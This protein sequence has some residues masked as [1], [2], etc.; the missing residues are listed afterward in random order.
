MS[1]TIQNLFLFVLLTYSI[2]PKTEGC[3]MKRWQIFVTNDMSS[4]IVVHVESRDDDLG[5]HLIPPTANYKFSFCDNFFGQSIFHGDFWRGSNFQGLFLLDDGIRQ[6]CSLPKA[7]DEYCYWSVRSDGFYVSPYQDRGGDHD[8]EISDGCGVIH[9]HTLL[10]LRHH[11]RSTTTPVRCN[12]RTK[13]SFSSTRPAKSKIDRW[14]LIAKMRR[15]QWRCQ[16]W[17]SMFGGGRNRCQFS[18]DHALPPISTTY[19]RAKIKLK[20]PL[21]SPHL[22]DQNPPIN[23]TFRRKSFG[24]PAAVTGFNM[25]RLVNHIQHYSLLICLIL[26]SSF[27]SI[28]NACFFTTKWKVY[29][30]NST[31]DNIITRVRSKDDDLG[32]HLVPPNG[33]YHWSFCDRFDRTTTFDGA[34]WWGQDYDCLEVFAELARSKCNRFGSR[35]ES[36]FWILRSEGFYISPLNISFPDPLWMFVKPWGSG[37]TLCS[38][39][40]ASNKT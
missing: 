36:C 15:V 32:R 40:L 13:E 11:H 12:Q 29:I 5:K 16:F 22:R 28:T 25:H 4:D 30:I 31:P 2:V 9:R 26:A 27:S 6:I 3:F 14:V 39:H 21:C 34:F 33:Y 10:F 17:I 1:S 24:P 35:V 19:S 20:T 23:F 18:A 37:G 7:G 8:V 38:M